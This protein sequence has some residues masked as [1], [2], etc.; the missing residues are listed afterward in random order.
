VDEIVDKQET[1]VWD[2]IMLIVQEL[3]LGDHAAHK[4]FLHMDLS[5]KHIMTAQITSNRHAKYTQ[6]LYPS[7][8]T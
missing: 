8:K 5:E 3:S 1:A 7:L 6:K 2:I 4:T